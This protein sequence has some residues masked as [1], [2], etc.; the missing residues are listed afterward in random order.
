MTTHEAALL[1]LHVNASDR[2]HGKPLYEAIVS[3]AHATGLRGASVFPVAFGF[4][5]RRRI[6]DNAS[7]YQFVDEPVI[8]EIIDTSEKIDSLLATI[9]P[10]FNGGLMTVEPVRVLQRSDTP[11][12]Q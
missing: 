2:W 9:G 1:R 5:E 3:A 11:P 6:H 8:I 10:M 7:E 12:S 4:G